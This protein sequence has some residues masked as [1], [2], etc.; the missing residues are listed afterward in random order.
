ML[1]LLCLTL[2]VLS[3]LAGRGSTETGTIEGRVVS[4]VTGNAI[5]AAS[6]S[7]GRMTVKDTKAAC[8]QHE[9]QAGPD[10]TF[11]LEH[12]PSGSYLLIALAERYV[13]VGI[14]PTVNIDAGRQPSDVVLE[15]NPVATIRGVV[16]DVNDKPARGV[17][18]QALM[19]RATSLVLSKRAER[20]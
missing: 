14:T 3:Q 5:P 4:S 10:G 9:V 17:I 18:V 11:R 6:V 20:R 19:P 8:A 1:F 7:V 12:I 13:A 16:R 2:S 15:L